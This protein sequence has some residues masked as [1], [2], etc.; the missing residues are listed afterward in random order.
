M[1]K[2]AFIGSAG[3]GKSTIAYGLF[4]H[5]KVKGFKTEL[6]PELIKIKV[7]KKENFSR[8]GFDI[9]NTLEQ[10]DLENA[11]NQH[12]NVL[13]YLICE[14]PLV[15]GFFYST[16]YRKYHE[17]GALKEIANKY[18]KSY[19]YIYFV[20][21]GEMN[22][23]DFDSIGRKGTFEET[24]GVE[25]HIMQTLDDLGISKSH[26]KIINRTVN[27]SDIVRDITK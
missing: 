18:V 13:D 27:I 19:D 17:V 12:G 5:L 3:V 20:T 25:S 11:F 14:S 15:N 4:H 22:K 1:K 16:Y 23:K 24:L 2:I 6:V 7:Y 21:A 9:Q 10:E 8:I 26:V